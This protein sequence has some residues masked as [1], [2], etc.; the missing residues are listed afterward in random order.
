LGVYTGAFTPSSIPLTPSQPAG[1]NIS[2]ITNQTSLLVN[3]SNRFLN[4]S[5]IP[6]MFDGGTTLNFAGTPTIQRFSPFSTKT[7]SK[8]YSTYFNGSSDYLQTPAGTAF[9]YGTGDFTIECWVY[10]TA[11]PPSFGSMIWAQTTSG[12]NYLMVSVQPALTIVWTDVGGDLTS[13]SSITL[14]AWYHVAVSR[15]SGTAKI[16]INGTQVLST[17]RTTDYS[18]TTYVPTI[19][20]YSHSAANWLTGYVSNV[21]VIKGQ[22]L[23]TGAFTP[24]TSTLTSTTVGSTGLG[25]AASI[26]GTVSLLTCQDNTFIDNSSNKFTITAGTT[27]VKPLLVSPFTPTASTLPV[28]YSTATFGG[29]MYFDGTTDQ[30][31]L[32]NAALAVIPGDFTIEGWI[33]PNVSQTY[34]P[35]YTLGTEASGRI[36]FYLNSTSGQLSIARYGQGTDTTFTTVTAKLNAWAHF[37]FVRVGSTITGYVNGVTAGTVSLSGSLGVGTQVSIMVS[38]NT[39]AWGTGYLSDVRFTNAALYTGSFYPN[40]TPLTSTPTI[41]SSTYISSLLL[42]GTRGAIVDQTRTVDFETVG[43]TTLVNFTPFH[44][45]YYSY[46]IPSSGSSIGFTQPALGNVF[47][48]EM[49]IFPTTVESNNFMYMGISSGPIIG[50][51]ST[52]FSAAHQ[53]SWTVAASANPTVG[54]WSHIALVREGTG[55]NQFKLYLNGT[56]VGTGTEATT[57]GSQSAVIG[58]NANA[59]YT[60]YIHSLRVVNNQA[61]YTGSFTPATSPLTSTLVGSTGAGAASSIT[62]TVALLTM[63]NKTIVDNSPSPLTLTPNGSIFSLGQNPFQVNTGVSC[64][65]DGT[66]DY[67]VTWNILPFAF[68]TG[69]L[70]M[71]AWVYRSDS[72]VQRAIID[73]RGSASVGILFYVANEKLNLFDSS[74]TYLT[75]TNT[76]PV[77][78]WVHVAVSR[79]SGTTKLFIN[80]ALEATLANDTRNYQT[81]SVGG[82]MVGRQ[83]GS[84][85]NDWYGYI[86]DVRITS[87]SARYTA[88]FTPPSSPVRLS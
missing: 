66:G 84:T 6:L 39:D 72:S 82:V 37:A 25:A 29:S 35:L 13:S 34:I 17:S 59:S 45:N 42:G 5:Y 32:A 4:N 18:N 10:L 50:Y 20:R 44:G 16:F 23:Y 83:Y 79:S 46:N 12:S 28:N 14:N 64:Y 7:V 48:I 3:Q 75:S 19:G 53:G 65:F 27:T 38:A 58:G 68:N 70:T 77:G 40:S 73:T 63:Q 60:G 47:T 88:T 57:F 21:R 26:T 67:L 87:G 22:A 52:T 71:E 61:L 86:T 2:A 55:S 62:G 81:N 11:T 33:Y 56:L 51:N 80:G 15:T 85:S 74:S 49:W 76:V 24:S 30:L 54:T 31:R 9:A 69:D 1:T 78:L 36:S 43:D 41:G 8:Y